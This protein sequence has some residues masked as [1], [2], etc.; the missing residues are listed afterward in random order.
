MPERWNKWHLTGMQRAGS[1]VVLQKNDYC[2][3]LGLRFILSQ[4]CSSE[5]TGS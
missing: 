3:I 1:V 5:S 2:Q 4:P